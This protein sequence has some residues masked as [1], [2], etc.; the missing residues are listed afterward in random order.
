MKIARNLIA[1]VV[2]GIGV[3]VLLQQYAVLY[4]T[5]T[6]AIIGIVLGIAVQFG[7][8]A[9]FGR[10]PVRVAVATT[11]APEDDTA[12]VIEQYPNADG[13]FPSHRVPED[14]LTTWAEPDP[15]VGAGARL[16][17][18]LAVHVD[19]SRGE[20]AHVVCENGWSAW[21]PASRLEEWQ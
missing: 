7:V 10:A 9:A 4:P 1:G 8:G 20:W 16:D 14:G 19:E 3:V 11:T 21:V 15:A 18:H 13:W 2:S 12:G 5:G 6:I 17:P